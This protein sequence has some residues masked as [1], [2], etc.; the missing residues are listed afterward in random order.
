[1]AATYD[2]TT[3]DIGN[4]VYLEHVNVQIPDQGTATRFY[5]AGLGLTR[6]PYLMVG[7]DNMWVNVGRSQFH[8]PS[9]EPA[10]QRVRG[11]V[12]LVVPDLDVTERLLERAAPGLD[13]T[14]F[15]YRRTNDAIEATCP[16]GNRLRVH[17]PSA[18]FGP[19]DL[20]MPYVEFD[21]PVGTAERIA[22]FYTEI[23]GASAKVTDRGG[24]PAAEVTAGAFQALVF[25]ETEAPM[26]EYDGHHVAIYIT[27]FSGPYRKL[28][29]R[30][31][32]SRESN[33]HEWRFTDIIDLDTSEVLFVVEHET[34][35]LTHPMFGRPL[36][37][38]NPVQTQPA[39]QRGLDR[40]AGRA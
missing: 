19:V 33:Q 28:I 40:F 1:M 35:S 32:I 17:A 31:L 24:A 3:E 10:P 16:W 9:R 5:V 26:P 4:I 12:G 6:D 21:V 38:R 23:M 15:G 29:D 22:R 25:R 27:D 14:D 37:N 34:R 18:A 30:G 20:G 11:T 39:Y 7:T 13:G 8:M 2:R 36:V